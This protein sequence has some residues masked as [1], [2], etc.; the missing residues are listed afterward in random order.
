MKLKKGPVCVLCSVSLLPVQA[1]ILPTYRISTYCVDS[2]LL[3][4]FSMI[5]FS[6]MVNQLLTIKINLQDHAA[7][8]GQA[9]Q[10]SACCG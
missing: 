9:A 7:N 10:K 8:G 1:H 6:S 4:C 5:I 3:A 2:F